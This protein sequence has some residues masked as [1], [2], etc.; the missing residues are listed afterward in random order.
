MKIYIAAKFENREP[1]QVLRDHLRKLGHTVT[2]D[3]TVAENQY[4]A[5]YFGNPDQKLVALF[6][7][8]GATSCDVMVIYPHIKGRGQYVEM[9]AALALGKP[10][11]LMPHEPMV[12]VF[13]DHPCVFKV[14]AEEDVIDFISHLPV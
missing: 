11:L 14:T 8:R 4:T 12:C 9:G 7:L 3:W 6:D 1:V 5:D 10:V 2:Y 13:F